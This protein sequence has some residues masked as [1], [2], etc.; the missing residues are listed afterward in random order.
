M[1]PL[2]YVSDEAPG[3]TRRRRGKGFAYFRGSGFR[4]S[5]FRGSGKSARPV[6]DKKTIERVKALAIPPA[7]TDVWICPDPEGHLQATG[8][9][10][11]GR[12]QYR[13]HDEWRRRRDV[14]KFERLIE[15][16]EALTTMRDRVRRDLAKGGL[17]PEA[18]FAAV[19]RLLDR[20]HARVGNAAYQRD[21]ATFGLTTLREKHADVRGRRLRLCYPGKGGKEVEVE[22]E[23]E[24][25]ARIVRKCS[26]LPGRELFQYVD[27]EGKRCPVTSTE[28][29][30]YIREISGQNGG[31]GDDDPGLSAKDFRT[32]GATVLAVDR[33]CRGAD[34]DGDRAAQA[35]EA[36]EFVAERLA[37]TPAIARSAYVDPRV[38]EEHE[39][40]GL[41]CFPPTRAKQFRG[42]TVPERRLMT[43][44]RRLAKA[45]APRSR[46][47]KKADR[48]GDGERQ[49]GMRSG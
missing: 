32:W 39:R 34:A 37:N 11:R 42:L 41:E 33:L 14:V 3:L 49:G 19:V 27:E 45:K 36:I 43:V 40:N 13:Y 48:E 29:N 18:V 1:S 10:A 17:P 23:D 21:N 12:K 47:G 26:D 46:A 20:T 2:H 25:L 30:D 16:G 28:V 7:W 4:G 9:D 24:R 38:I 35:K 22:L 15:F 6:R 31:G 8:R 44:L 5:G